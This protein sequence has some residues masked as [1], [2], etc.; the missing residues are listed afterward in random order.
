MHRASRGLTYAAGLAAH[1]LLSAMFGLVYAWLIEWI[2]PATFAEG[3]AAGLLIGLAH[4]AVA[5]ILV[6]RAL[7]HLNAPVPGNG[8][9]GE[10]V[11]DGHRRSTAVVWIAA[12]GVFGLTVAAAYTVATL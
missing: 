8:S 7:P 11:L 2:A 4:G 10:V 5:T 6:A 1:F 3:A 12:H 9:R